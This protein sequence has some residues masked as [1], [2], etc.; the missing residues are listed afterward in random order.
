MSDLRHITERLRA[1]LAGAS[2]LGQTV[3]IDLKGDGVIFVDGPVVS[4]E[5]RP[6][7]CTLTLRLDDLTALAQGRLDPAMAM[8]RGRLKIQGDMAPALKLQALL[9]RAPAVE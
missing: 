1:A 2:G 8:M 7:D 5:N 4:N 3:K 9:A 6:A